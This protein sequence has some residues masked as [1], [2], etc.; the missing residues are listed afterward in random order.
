MEELKIADVQI[1]IVKKNIKNLHLSVHP[2][3]GRVR[4]AAPKTMSDEAIRVFAI[5]KLSWIK[6]QR[7]KFQNQDRQS[8]REFVSGESHYFLG[9]RYLLNVIYTSKKQR[10]ELIKN[11]QIDLYVRENSTTEQR[12][13]VM[14]E[15]YRSFLKEQIPVIISKWEKEIGVKVNSWGVKLMKTKWG[16]CNIEAKRIWLNL[17][18]AKKS[19]RCLEYIIVHE[20]IHLLERNHNDRFHAHMDMFMPNWKEIKAELNGMVFENSNWTY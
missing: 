19:P 4:I 16:T 12:E 14:S 3:Y 18:L 5:C 13:K 6:K 2:P 1:E 7:L 20:M 15:W 10:V 17:E 11:N 9:R 8:E